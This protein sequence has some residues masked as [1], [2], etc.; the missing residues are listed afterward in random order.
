M[1]YC[2]CIWFRIQVDLRPA[3]LLFSQLVVKVDSRH[4][5]GSGVFSSL[6]QG[7]AVASEGLEL[8]DGAIIITIRRAMRALLFEQSNASNQIRQ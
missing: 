7:P 2:N 3:S 4:Q 8:K 1:F 6:L 5:F